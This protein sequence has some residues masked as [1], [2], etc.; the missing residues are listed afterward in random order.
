M[1]CIA[2]SSPIYVGVDV[3]PYTH[4]ICIGCEVENNIHCNYLKKGECNDCKNCFIVNEQGEIPTNNTQGGVKMIELIIIII[5]E[6][7][8]F[9]NNL[10]IN[11]II[12]LIESIWMD[13]IKEQRRRWERPIV[14]NKNDGSDWRRELL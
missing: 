7:F 9:I 11:K 6:F 1:K 2:F 8:L 10:S 13:E 3:C 4:E 5:D 12:S 14:L